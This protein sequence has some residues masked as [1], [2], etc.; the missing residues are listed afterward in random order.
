VREIRLYFA[1][2]NWSDLLD[3]L[4][5]QGDDRLI[6]DLVID[7][8]SYPDV[9]VR[10]KGFS[11][12]S[13]SRE[14]NPFNIK[15][16][17][18]HRGQNHQGYEKLKLSNVIQDPSFLRE[19]MSYE[20]A[21]K[22]MPASQAGF[23]NVFVND[24]LIGLYTNVEDV[25][26]EFVEKHFGSRNNAFVKGNP[27][28]VDLNGENSNLSDTPG[29]DPEAYH[30]LYGLES[31]EGWE[32]LLELIDVLNNDQAAIPELLNVDRALWMHAINYTLI[33]FDSY[34]GYAQNYYLYKDD[35]GRWNP[36]LWDMNMSF[37][38]FRLT[39]ASLYWNGFSIAQAITMNPLNHLN[40]VSVQPRP[41]MRELFEN[42]TY[43]R[44]YLA[45]MRTILNENFA[46]GDYYDRALALR[47]LV[48]PH[49]LA[50]T[51]KFYS[52][53]DFESNLDHTVSD[54]VD[55]PG[56]GELMGPRNTYLQG[57]PG[58]SGQPT[59]EEVAHWPEEITVGGDVEITAR[60]V[61]S[62]SAFLAY[63]CEPNGLFEHVELRD[64]GMN[65]DGTA[66]DGMY[67]ARVTASTNLVEFYIYAEN[68]TAGAFSPERAA[69]EFHSFTTRI[70]TGTLVVNEIK[71][72]SEGTGTSDWIELYNAGGFPLSTA[73][74]HLSDD[75]T[76]PAKWAMPLRVVA[77]GEYL[78]VWA[79]GEPDQGADHANFKLDAEGESLL[80]SYADGTVI[81]QVQ[82]GSQYP[83]S[84]TGRYPNGT[85]SFREL[86]PTLGAVNT[87]DGSADLD[88]HIRIFPNPTAGDLH[89]IV[90]E[91]GPFELRVIRS[92]GAILTPEYSLSGDGLVTISALNFGAGVYVLELQ[93]SSTTTRTTFV[94]I[95]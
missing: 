31:D 49:V 74:L 72:Y 20:V 19:A 12:Y 16:D 79:D 34:V 35:N 78:V 69:Y 44:M 73:G 77:P 7:G 95:Q 85:G 76:D 66:G 14:K 42:D 86:Y 70:T 65:G 24:V 89:L 40:S 33:N 53:A 55:Y 84:T 9:G 8:T 82:Y 87:N 93:T 83:M 15:L 25:S 23:A 61:G 67:G 21:R 90:D 59:I 29:D 30:D 88:R 6:G 5:L 46:N 37:A 39:D 36:I 1:E 63:R 28:T 51:N 94:S 3:T 50:D 68:A 10:Y 75:P 41:L 13:S 47:D 38:S 18:I 11:S 26:K 4:Y 60:I 57:R 62:D 52:D 17:H 22:Y 45:H 54:V 32:E 91:N 64:D 2:E 58:F 92:D 48:R 71:A 43:K 80:L 27:T 56:I 81:D